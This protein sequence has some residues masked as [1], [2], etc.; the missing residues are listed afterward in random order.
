MR[1]VH[2]SFFIKMGDELIAVTKYARDVA[3]K[4][5]WREAEML[6]KT[7][8]ETC[9]VGDDAL[10]MVFPVTFRKQFAPL[11]NCDVEEV[12][13]RIDPELP[14]YANVSVFP[15][16]SVERDIAKAVATEDCHSAKAFRASHWRA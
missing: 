8:N 2:C 12:A 15:A 13:V 7:D 16:S 10:P 6:V 4:L 14:T 9:A 1:N 5:L 11:E 3:L